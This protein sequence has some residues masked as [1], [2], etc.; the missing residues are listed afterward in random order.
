MNWKKWRPATSESA[1]ARRRSTTSLAMSD[2]T[3]Q[4]EKLSSA[5]MGSSLRSLRERAQFFFALLPEG[6]SR[7]PS[8]KRQ[9]FL[10]EHGTEYDGLMNAV[11]PRA[12]R[13]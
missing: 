4:R 8:D 2:Q 3:L 7:F 11:G 13:S 5:A 10:E 1:S 6:D 12:D 9:A